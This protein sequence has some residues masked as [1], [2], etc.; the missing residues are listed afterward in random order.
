[1]SAAQY[2]AERARLPQVVFVVLNWNQCSMTLD[3]LA[4]LRKQDYP[5]YHIV[6]V[7]NGSTDGSQS[8][9]RKMHPDVDVIEAG[10]NLGYS[11]GNNLGIQ[12]ALELDAD[13]VFLLNNDTEVDSSMLPRLIQVAE[14]DPKIGMVG[15]TMYYADP[16]NMVWGGRNRIDWKRASLLREHMG[17]NIDQSLLDQEA[18]QQT[19]YVDTCAVLVKR[20]VIKKIGS[21]DGRYFINFD[22][23]DWNTRTSRAGYKIVYAPSARMWHKVS[24]TMGLASPATTYYMTRNALLFF[25][26]NGPGLWRVLGPLQIALRTIRT[27]AAWTLKRQYRTE[28]FRRKRDANVLALRDFCLGRFGKMGGDVARICSHQ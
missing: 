3:C 19:D 10:R 15:P 18:P 16:P 17:E 6:V 4:S 24:A 28:V 27:I 26:A 9:I 11:P 25:S 7:D 13:Y 21:L 20:E 1:M 2:S 22:D 14:T 8:S 12:R 23:F 5:R